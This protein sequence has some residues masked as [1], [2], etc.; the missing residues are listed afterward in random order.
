MA[1]PEASSRRHPPVVP[2]CV[3]SRCVVQDSIAQMLLCVAVGCALAFV[4]AAALSRSGRKLPLLELL[5]RLVLAAG[6]VYL[7]ADYVLYQGGP[8]AA[9][10]AAAFALG[11]CGLRGWWLPHRVPEAVRRAVQGV[12]PPEEALS[13]PTNRAES[14]GIFYLAGRRGSAS[15]ARAAL[16][17]RILAVVHDDRQGERAR[18]RSMP[19]A[20]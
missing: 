19:S 16:R 10:A 18:D 2:P 14:G 20:A 8:V 7:G 13:A 15:A 3:G 17:S 11:L 5:P 12:T 6:P 4:V 9:C 1:S